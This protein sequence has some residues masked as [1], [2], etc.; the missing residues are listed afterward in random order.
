MIR[1][2]MKTINRKFFNHSRQLKWLHHRNHRDESLKLLSSYL[3]YCNDVHTSR[4]TIYH[5]NLTGIDLDCSLGQCSKEYMQGILKSKRYG[6]RS[7]AVTYIFIP[8]F[9][10]V[11]NCIKSPKIVKKVIKNLL[12]ITNE[13]LGIRVPLSCQNCIWN[14]M[15]N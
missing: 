4:V 6:W 5:N 15:C 8:K 14:N 9:Q 1:I 7:V 10:N 11:I 3:G 2:C 12:G 13:H